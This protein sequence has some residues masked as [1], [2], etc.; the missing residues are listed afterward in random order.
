MFIRVIDEALEKLLRKEL[1]LPADVGDIAFDAP[2]SNW[3]AQLSRIAVN[4]FL[5]D[6]TRSNHPGRSPVLRRGP[7]GSPGERRASQ[8]MVQL[9]YLLSAWAGTPRD[10][11]QL[12]GD[13]VSVLAGI[14]QLSPELLSAPLSSSV[15]V[16]FADD[17]QYRTKD[18]WSA[19]GGN[20]KA[21][22]T[23]QVSVAADAFEWTEQAPA[24]TRIEALAAPRPRTPAG[25]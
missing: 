4:L 7:D 15:Y 16:G 8:P 10:E 25:R 22:F 2:T 17:G 14:E 9:S 6:V 20:L 19:L 24:V 23:L 21:S 1:P 12:L 11:H 3:S 13:V 18:I 5:H